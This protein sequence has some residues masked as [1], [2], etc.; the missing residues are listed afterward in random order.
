MLGSEDAGWPPTVDDLVKW[1]HMFQSVGTFCNYEGK[2]NCGVCFI[3]NFACDL[4]GYVRTACLALNIRATLAYEPALRRAKGA[5]I[6]RMMSSTRPKQFIQ[7]TCLYNMVDGVRK[8]IESQSYAMLWL[9][10]YSFMLRVP[11]EALKMKKGGDG[12]TGHSVIVAESDK[13]IALHLASRKNRQ[14]G[15]VVRRFCTCKQEEAVSHPLCVVHTLWNGFFAHMQPG[16]QPWA[17]LTPGEVNLHLRA[18]L[19]KLGVCQCACVCNFP[20]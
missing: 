14:R 1:S 5:I 4:Q 19:R 11:S 2:H 17:V 12:T 18:T 7:R 6:K 16:D 13:C 15:S 3:F 9:A 8:D 10:A 20:C